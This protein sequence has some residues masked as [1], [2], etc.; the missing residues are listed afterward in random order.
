MFFRIAR[1]APHA[2]MSVSIKDSLSNEIP[3]TA[4]SLACKNIASWPVFSSLLLL[5]LL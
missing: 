4:S 1:I 5:P 2:P 3:K